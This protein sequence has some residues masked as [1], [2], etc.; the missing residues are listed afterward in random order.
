[1]DNR[2][3]VTLV[4]VATVFRK[5][6]MG[7][8]RIRRW[9]D[10]AV[11]GEFLWASGIAPPLP[12]HHHPTRQVGMVRAGVLD[13]AIAGGFEGDVSAP[14]VVIVPPN[15]PHRVSGRLDTEVE[16]AQVELDEAENPFSSWSETAE[17]S[18]VCTDD[19]EVCHAFDELL[20]ASDQELRASERRA[21]LIRLA[22]T[23]RDAP[24][25]NLGRPGE[26]PVVDRVLARLDQVTDRSVTLAELAEAE[27]VSRSTL[28][29]RFQQ[30]LGASPHDYHVSVRRNVAFELM[31]NGRSVAEASQETGFHDQSHFTRHARTI[32]AMGPGSWR[33]RRRIKG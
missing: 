19:A 18:V 21:R 3:K 4:E 15:V 7:H 33:R 16:Y 26:D 11:R 10:E 30:K 2:F 24:V 9:R 6:D 29:R 31:N 17:G 8:T 25:L 5:H 27:K 23:V 1:L 22:E 28:L 20:L 32:L 14:C 13:V 12:M